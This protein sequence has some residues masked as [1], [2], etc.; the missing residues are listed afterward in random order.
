MTK[1]RK[2]NGQSPLRKRDLNRPSARKRIF[3][4]ASQLFYLKG[5]RAVGVETIAAEA[6]TTKMSLY[7][8]F[9]SKDE[10]VAEWLRDHDV[11]FW[12]TWDAMAS[13]H[14]KDPRRQL[15]AAF[16]LLARHVADPKARGC[17]MA[18][19]AVELTEKDHP[20]RKVIEAH[21]T[22]LRTRLAQMCNQM[23][24]RDPGLLAD[25]L[26]LLMEGAQVTT[27]TLGVRG[28]ARNV[29]RAAKTLIDAHLGAS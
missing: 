21:K 27:Q 14:P 24:V 22:K 25:H 2:S 7:R 6:D 5:I 3:D 18:N 9:P 29:A 11:N 28:P 8:N 4:T 19:A 1:N 10:L 17:R 20:A 13:R 16:A 23:G 15:K 12:Q 26:F